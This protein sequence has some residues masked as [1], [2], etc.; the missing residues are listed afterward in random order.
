MLEQ[1]CSYFLSVLFRSYRSNQNITK[2]SGTTRSIGA[3]TTPYRGLMSNIVD[4]G[5]TWTTSGID[6]VLAGPALLSSKLLSE[7]RLPLQHYFRSAN[8]HTLYCHAH[9]TSVVTFR[10]PSTITRATPKARTGEP[11]STN[12]VSTRKATLCSSSAVV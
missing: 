6:G 8:V 3:W 1:R 12:S 10:R 4:L 2:T 5:A 7:V 11:L 9:G